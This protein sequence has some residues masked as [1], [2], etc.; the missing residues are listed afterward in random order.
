MKSVICLIDRLGFGGAERQ[1]I[2]LAIL[3]QKKNCIVDLVTYDY[4][5]FMTDE[6]KNNNLNVKRRHASANKLSKFL[7]FRNQV[8]K[9]KYDCMIAYKP[10]PA[11]IGCMLKLI[12]VNFRLIVS[13][14]NTTQFIGRKE[15]IQFQLYRMADYV[16]PNSQSQVE[17]IKE[18]FPWLRKKT[19]P[20]TNFTD[21]NHFTAHYTHI[22]KTINILTVA[23]VA[24][25]KNVLRFLEAIEV[26]RKRGITHVHFDWYGGVQP[27]EEAYGNEVFKKVKNLQLEGLICFHPATTEILDMYQNCDIFCLPSNYEGFPN[28]ICEAMSCGKPIVCS[29]VCDNPNIVQDGQNGLLFDNTNVNDMADKLQSIC[30]LSQDVLSRWG[31]H[32]RE[33]AE[34]MFSMDVF[35]EKYLE[36]MS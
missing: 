17:F 25:Q 36:L 26:L 11:I 35:V 6:I 7:A 13:E 1:M 10:G 18:H 27:G 15:K 16:I 29:R 5:D 30:S 12:G 31:H 23:R 3:L 8:R 2:G 9:K 34:T 21:T 33:I 20:I 32:S 4:H 22:G 24:E 28:V 19:I 14:R